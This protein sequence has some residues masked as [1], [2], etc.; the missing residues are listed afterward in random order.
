M[1]SSSFIN[2]NGDLKQNKLS[3]LIYV[4]INLLQNIFYSLF[5]KKFKLINF[6]PKIKKYTFKNEQSISRK[7]CGVFGKT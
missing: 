6:N 7:L 5:S 4:F 2:I 1:K 3:I